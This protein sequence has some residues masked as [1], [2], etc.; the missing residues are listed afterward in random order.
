MIISKTQYFKKTEVKVIR[1]ENSQE[2]QSLLAV[3]RPEH[4]G[5][6]EPV[7]LSKWKSTPKGGR[8][9]KS[10]RDNRFDSFHLDSKQL[11]ARPH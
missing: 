1:L 9:E 6:L 4:Q 10:M 2:L 11:R 5:G 3:A 8:E 7:P